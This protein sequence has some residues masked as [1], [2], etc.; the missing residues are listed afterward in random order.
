MYELLYELIDAQ[1]DH[2]RDL[3][4]FAASLR[5]SKAPRQDSLPVENI[6]EG[7]RWRGPRRGRIESGPGVPLTLKHVGGL[8]SSVMCAHEP[9]C[10]DAEAC[11][12]RSMEQTSH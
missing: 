3:E 1:H 7:R 2:L 4:E 12:R 10:E 6:A 11:I 5:R 8:E 9:S